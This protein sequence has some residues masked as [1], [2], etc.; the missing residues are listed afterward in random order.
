MTITSHTHKLTGC[1]P[2][3]L[4]H[5]LK[6][7]GVLRLVSEG[8][9]PHAEGWWAGDVFHLRTS[10]PEAELCRFFLEE[11]RPTPIVGPWGTRIRFFCRR[12]GEISKRGAERYRELRIASPPVVWYGNPN[13]ATSAYRTKAF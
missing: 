11:Y 2:I 13:G 4:A 7:L 10:L 8:P 1:A 3:P 12:L 5:Y 6:A 9:D